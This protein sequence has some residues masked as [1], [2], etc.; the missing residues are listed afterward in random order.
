MNTDRGRLLLFE[1]DAAQRYYYRKYVRG[2]QWTKLT[3]VQRQERIRQIVVNR[4]RRLGIARLTAW[5]ERS[6]R[7]MLGRWNSLKKKALPGGWGVP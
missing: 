4:S 6:E 3:E 7:R 1:P 5:S 2:I